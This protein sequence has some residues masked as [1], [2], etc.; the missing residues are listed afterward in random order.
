M[1]GVTERRTGRTLLILGSK[2]HHGE[3]MQDQFS[4]VIWTPKMIE[5]TKSYG[6]TIR[7]ISVGDIKN[8]FIGLDYNPRAKQDDGVATSIEDIRFLAQ[9]LMEFGYNPEKRLFLLKPPYIV[10]S[11]QGKRMRRERKESLHDFANI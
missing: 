4:N 6:D 1:K 3:A 9:M 5:D 7:W 2:A 11:E 10:E 8:G